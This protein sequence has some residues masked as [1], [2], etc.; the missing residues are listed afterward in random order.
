[1]LLQDKKA[2][3][4]WQCRRGMLELDLIFARFLEARIDCMTESELMSFEKFLNHSD[5]D[6]Y[7]WLMGYEVPEDKECVDFAAFIGLHANLQ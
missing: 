1:M 2:K 4:R 5:P 7:A 3:L 6:L